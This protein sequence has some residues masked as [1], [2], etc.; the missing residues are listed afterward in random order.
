LAEMV[1]SSG[2]WAKQ[3]KARDDFERNAGLAITL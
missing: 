1:Q 2:E 3:K